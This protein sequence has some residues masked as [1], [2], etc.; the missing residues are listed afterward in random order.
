[1]NQVIEQLFQLKTIDFRQIAI[2][3]FVELMFNFI[4]INNKFNNTVEI[5][6]KS[7]HNQEKKTIDSLKYNLMY[8]LILII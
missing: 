6:Y 2:V 3:Q 7:L 8:I 4:Y 5:I 1:M